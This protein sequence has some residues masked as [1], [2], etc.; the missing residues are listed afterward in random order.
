VLPTGDAN[1]QRKYIDNRK[2]DE[3]EQARATEAFKEL[4]KVQ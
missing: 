3:R 1:V 4:P 2:R